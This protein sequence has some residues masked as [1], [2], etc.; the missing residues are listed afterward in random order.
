M[1]SSDLLRQGHSIA[2]TKRIGLPRE[3][4]VF[5]GYPDS[6][7]EKIFALN[8]SA[9]FEQSFTHKRETYGLTAPDYHTAKQ[10]IPA[11]Y[12]KASVVNDLAEI[13][14]ERRPRE[15]YVTHPADTHP[16]HRTAFSFVRE[17]LAASKRRAALFT[18]IVHGDPP[19]ELPARRLSLTPEQQKT[20]RAAIEDHQKGTSPIHDALADT[21]AK[22]EEIFWKAEVEAAVR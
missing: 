4:L 16:D 13:I 9:V 18:Y 7:L 15:I 5:L 8:S 21:Y 11:P 14:R 6:G 10:S 17:A 22:P 20:K 2:A 19:P 1:C 12:L 3:E